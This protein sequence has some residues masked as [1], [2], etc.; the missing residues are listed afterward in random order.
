MRICIF[1]RILQAH[2]EFYPSIVGILTPV[3]QALGAEVTAITSALPDGS[4]EV[5]REGIAE[6]HY[7]A[8][9][10][11][12]RMDERFWRATAAAFDRLHEEKP[13]DI[14]MGRGVAT[15]GFFRYSRYAGQVPVVLHEGTYP[16]WLHKVE[17]RTGT[18]APMLAR[19][20]APV[21][22][23]RNRREKICMEGAARVVCITPALARALR[24]AYWWNPPRTVA[25]TYGF[26]TDRYHPAPATHPARLVSLGRMTWDKGILPMIDVLARVR[27]RTVTLEAM[28]PA[29]PEKLQAVLDH[30]G[31]RGVAD[32]YSAPGPV[33]HDQVPD[34]LAGALAFL[35]PSTHA[36]GLGKVVL[37]A[38][39][40]GLPVIAYDLPVM[41]GLIEEGR[42]GYLVPIRS[43][44]AMAERVERLLADPALR[45]RMGAAA[46]AKLEAEFAPAVINAQWRAL[47]DEVV[48]EARGAH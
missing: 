43:V 23:W 29:S 18:L 22:G 44:S 37:E 27:D 19:V 35:F 9:T 7:L 39:A 21:F 34:R 17:T 31:K 1:A 13:F 41:E 15:L 38:M 5:R 16:R 24:R 10:T 45:D 47:L 8:G 46:R 40:A 2:R 28:G 42:T 30:A 32:R 20:L 11:P 3:F 4:A 12:D 25:L 48:A 14:I 33:K 36:E 6:A 26:E